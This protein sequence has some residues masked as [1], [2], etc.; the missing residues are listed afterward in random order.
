MKNLKTIIAFTLL[1][2]VSIGGIVL[3][4][5]DK[6]NDVYPTSNTKIILYGE[7]H[8]SKEYYDAEL[9][10]WQGFYADGLRDLFLELPYYSAEFLNVWM[11]E[12]SNALLDTW[13][14][15][16]NGTLSGNQYYYDFFC[17]IK[18][19][20]PDT[21]FYGT[22]VGHQYDTT[23]ARYLKYLGDNGLKDS[24]NYNL[25]EDCILQG[26]KYYENREDNDGVSELRE[27][28]MVSNFKKAYERQGRG[29]I[30]GIYGSYH[31]DLN[32][33][34]MASR[35]KADLGNII[36]S[37]K[38]SSVMIKGKNPYRFGI[39]AT[40]LILLA[41]LFAPNVIWAH[42]KK[43][44]DYDKSKKSENKVLLIFERVG[45][46]LVT[47]S[48]LIFPSINPLIVKLPDGVYFSWRIALWLESF[49]LMIF[50]ECYWINLFKSQREAKD[51]YSSFLGFPLAGATLPVIVVLLLGVYSKN[52]VLVASAIIFCIGHVGIHVAHKREADAKKEN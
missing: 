45:E 42:C 8:G 15:E 34:V 9:E 48:L 44:K 33:D 46:V 18:E 7:S 32:S 5:N 37:V 4:L 6:S 10:L 3:D 24:I 1:L 29:K 47:I 31:T 20:C 14:E 41:M 13:F 17:T 23:G 22:D 50:Y 2:V 36:S 39:S 21:V 12:D 11:D 35:L 28:Y 51:V 30:M 19:S 49:I 25:T 27:T 26:K 40:G 16:I 43:S 38:V 52:L